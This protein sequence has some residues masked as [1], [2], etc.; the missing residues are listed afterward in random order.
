MTATIAF[1]GDT[2]YMEKGFVCAQ[3]VDFKV[4]VVSKKIAG[5][6]F[7][8]TVELTLEQVSILITTV[9]ILKLNNSSH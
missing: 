4:G 1:N 3:D 2:T 8:G 6:Q 5:P 9:Q 7:A